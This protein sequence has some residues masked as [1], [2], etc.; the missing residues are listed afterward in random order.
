[1]AKKRKLKKEVMIFILICLFFVIY[2]LG[3]KFG[4]YLEKKD[5]VTIKQEQDED[6]D[7]RSLMSQISAKDKIYVSD[8]KVENVKIETDY[9]EGMKFLF[10]GFSKIRKPENYTPI[11]NGYSDDGIRFSTNLNYFR[12]YTVNKEEFYKIPVENKSEVEKILNNSIYTSF[13]LIKQY[14]TW[15][16]VEISYGGNVKTIHKW[17]YDDI[18]YN[19]ASKRMVGKVQPERSKERSDYNFTINI[20]GENYE[21]K[22]ETMGKDYIKITCGETAS[23]YEVYTGLFDYIKNDIFKIEGQS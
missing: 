9:W 7:S 15:K 17:K 19:M 3:F 13:D 6:E 23:Y 18:A 12:I 16:N 22:V 5:E 11:Y 10:K 8:S 4:T 21:V 20:R 1:M 2:I 14:K